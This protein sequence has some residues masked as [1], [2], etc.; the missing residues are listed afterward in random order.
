MDAPISVA[1]NEAVRHRAGNEQR[2]SGGARPQGGRQARGRAHKMTRPSQP[3]HTDGRASIANK[4]AASVSTKVQELK[5]AKEDKKAAGV[6][7]MTNR[8]QA[9]KRKRRGCQL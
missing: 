8:I 3:E 6:N 4:N 5:P 7:T 2:K 9:F 1:L